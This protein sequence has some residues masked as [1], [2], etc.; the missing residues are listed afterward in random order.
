MNLDVFAIL[1]EELKLLKAR[2]ETSL[3]IDNDVLTKLGEIAEMS[4]D[5]NSKK[6]NDSCENYPYKNNKEEIAVE[7]VKF[8]SIDDINFSSAQNNQND[9][10]ISMSTNFNI[11]PIPSPKEFK[12]PSKLLT[13]QEQ[14]NWLENK[15]LN[16]PVCNEHLHEGK[17]LVFGYGDIDAQILFCGEA[18]GASEE[19][20]G[21]PFVGRAG[22]LLT[23]IIEAMGLSRQSV[24][25]ANIMKWRPELDT[26]SG[27]R[28]P[29]KEEIAFC[30]PYLKH[31]VDIIKPKV[32]VALG[33][34]AAEGLLGRDNKR[35]ISLARG[36][37]YDFENTPLILT[38]HP[39]YI[40]RCNTNEKKRLL[41]EDLLE[42]MR[43]CDMPISQKQENYF[44]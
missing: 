29:T 11:K 15:V 20:T 30:L 25:I 43:K 31:Q 9:Q 13:K 6:D 40:L 18:P 8:A 10:N 4:I 23:K 34:T 1:S 32:I 33:K 39:A 22:K 12:I 5:S 7:P 44:L 37:W 17:K 42:A 21:E 38:Y 26:P 35:K 36:K 3:C 2:G 19:E 16:C 14:I 41:W 24:Y 28:P 27:N